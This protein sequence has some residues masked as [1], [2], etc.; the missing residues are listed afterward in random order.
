MKQYGVFLF[1]AGA[2]SPFSWLA[3]PFTAVRPEGQEMPVTCDSGIFRVVASSESPTEPVD[4]P[5]VLRA[6]YVRIDLSALEE[7]ARRTVSLNLFD[8]VCARA[9]RESFRRSGP[10]SFVWTGKLERDAL[11]EVT[12]VLV[13]GVLAGSIRIDERHFQLRLAHD[14][15]YRLLEIDQALY[16]N[17]APP[18]D[19][20]K[21]PE[22]GRSRQGF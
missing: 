10:Q 1:V 7:S 18:L 6:R 12:L 22:F 4:G 21:K 11:G 20:K 16:P 3:S 17:E 15:V 5:E 9:S 19:P 8:D 2:L 14:D 13:D